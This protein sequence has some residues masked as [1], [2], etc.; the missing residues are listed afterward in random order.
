M[1][2]HIETE[3]PQEFVIKQMISHEISDEPENPPRKGMQVT[4]KSPT[5]WSR[6]I[7]MV[8]ATHLNQL[9]TYRASKLWLHTSVWNSLFQRKLV[10]SKWVDRT[11][12]EKTT[13]ST[14][15]KKYK[16]KS[17]TSE[18]FCIFNVETDFQFASTIPTTCSLKRPRRKPHSLRL[19]SARLFLGSPTST[20][21]V[22][23]DGSFVYTNTCRT[24]CIGKII[25][26]QRTT[27]SS[28]DK[29]YTIFLIAVHAI[30]TT[31]L[32]IFIFSSKSWEIMADPYW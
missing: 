7:K 16:A 10:T 8:K 30:T 12:M 17:K 15:W 1:P 21:R 32:V 4:R 19:Q 27:F 22:A 29:I 26:H 28:I 13:A 2:K 20:K 11:I 3:K 5:A 14:Y 24:T 6:P 25:L 31:I 9:N 23:N 18:N